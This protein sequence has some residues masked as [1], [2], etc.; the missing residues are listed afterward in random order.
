M[1]GFAWGWALGAILGSPTGFS[2]CPGQE[3]ALVV[4]TSSRALYLCS[5]AG[6][7][8]KS[9]AVSLGRG[10]LDKRKQGD[11][12]TPLGTYTLG[13]PRPSRAGFDTFIPVGYPTRRQRA[14]GLTGSAIGVHGPPDGWPEP[15]VRFGMRSDWT[16]GCIMVGT[17]KEIRTIASWVRKT[18]ARRIDIYPK[19]DTEP[20]ADRLAH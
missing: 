3:P 19:K 8:V 11:R 4:E 7:A 14:R 15:V 6:K 12:R 18:G 13:A 1:A 17:V 5:A 10:G 9:F 2:H 20:A 16:D